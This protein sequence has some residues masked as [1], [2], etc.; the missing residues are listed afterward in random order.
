[1]TIFE[2]DQKYLAKI[3]RMAVDNPNR[4]VSELHEAHYL[5]ESGVI[6]QNCY[7]RVREIVNQCKL[8]LLK[9]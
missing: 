7:E 6:S 4:L 8:P 1:M 2:N 5:L 3:R 9:K